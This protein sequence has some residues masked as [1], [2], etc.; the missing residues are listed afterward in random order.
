VTKMSNSWITDVLVQLK[1]RNKKESE[2]FRSLMAS[3]SQLWYE[4]S[5]LQRQQNELKHR[6]GSFQ[7]DISAV[8]R[9]AASTSS[10]SSSTST[11]TSTAP[12][13]QIE[14]SSLLYRGLESLQEQLYS[15]QATLRERP[16][17]ESFERK[18][19]LDLSK[20]VREQQLLLS[21][22]VSCC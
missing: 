1:E 13:A 2:Q 12:H 6:I 3:H 19:R 22:Q 20:R 10:T 11:S 21:H 14:S 4:N 18:T 5:R 15:V 8:L 17:N 16:H 7:H 9:E